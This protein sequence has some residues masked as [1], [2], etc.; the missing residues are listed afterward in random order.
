MSKE[1]FEIWFLEAEND[2]QAGDILLKSKKYNIAVFHFVQA[3]EKAIKSLLYYHNLQPWGHSISDLIEQY[4]KLGNSVEDQLKTYG[5]KL[6]KH[7]ISSRYPDALPGKSPFE[8]YNKNI[9]TEIRTMSKEI[10]DFVRN[11]KK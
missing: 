7:Y 8:A 2:F 3:A 5:E 6:E 9:A 4:E 1:N 11:E 10:I